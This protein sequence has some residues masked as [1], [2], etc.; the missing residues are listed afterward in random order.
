MAA[1]FDDVQNK[2]YVDSKDKNYVYVEEVVSRVEVAIGGPQ[3]AK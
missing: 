2:V 3:G 1:E